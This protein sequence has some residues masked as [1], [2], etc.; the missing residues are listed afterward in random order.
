MVRDAGMGLGLL[1][2]F[3]FGLECR[4]AKVVGVMMLRLIGVMIC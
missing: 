1:C 3:M 2:L 4:C